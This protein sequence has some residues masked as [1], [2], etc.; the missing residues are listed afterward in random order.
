MN[1]LVALSLAGALAVAAITPAVAQ[2]PNCRLPDGSVYVV[3]AFGSNQDG[4]EVVLCAHQFDRFET[5]LET[6]G[7]IAWFGFNEYAW[8]WGV[9]REQGGDARLLRVDL[10]SGAY[11]D[12]GQFYVVYPGW[13]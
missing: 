10:E 9:V 5:P 6:E 13:D 4:H 1:R 2:N 12:L 3:R 11:E 7:H 8:A